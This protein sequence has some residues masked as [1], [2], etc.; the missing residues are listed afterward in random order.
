[1]REAQVYTGSEERRADGEA[2]DLNEKRD[3][4]IVGSHPVAPDDRQERS[5][6]SGTYLRI[7][8][9]ICH[10]TAHI[11]NDLGHAPEQHCNSESHPSLLASYT[12]SKKGERR[13]A[14]QDDKGE[15]GALSWAVGPI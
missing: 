14:E 9:I 15:V 5:L 4:R 12:L 6:Q 1:V 13:D 7:Q 10:D 11:S 8:I 3:L 2:D